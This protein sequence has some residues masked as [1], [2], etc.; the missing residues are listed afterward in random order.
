M[1]KASLATGEDGAYKPAKQNEP[2][3]CSDPGSDI[4]AKLDRLYVPVKS[5]I[6]GNDELLRFQWMRLH[7]ATAV[8]CLAEEGA[9]DIPAAIAEAARN[10]PIHQ[11][12]PLDINKMS[13]KTGA[14]STRKPPVMKLT[15]LTID[16]C[17]YLLLD[18]PL[19]SP[20]TDAMFDDD[21]DDGGGDGDGNENNGCEI[22]A[23]SKQNNS[24]SE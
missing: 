3:G 23:L 21:D 9:E 14:K 22:L 24:N 12:Q 5:P 15:D 8:A 17:E 6:T 7:P 4:E 10:F 2:T 16:L 20:M 11:E 18:P 1:D 19:L 13:A